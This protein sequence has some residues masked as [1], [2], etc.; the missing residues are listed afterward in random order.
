[1]GL[2]PRDVPRIRRVGLVVRETDM[3][4]SEWLAGLRDM[5]RR[6]GLGF[7]DVERRVGLGLRDIE[8]RVGL[9]FRDAERRVGLGFRAMERREGLGLREAERRTGLVLRDIDRPP[10]WRVGLVWRERG[11]AGTSCS[12]P[13]MSQVRLLVDLKADTAI[14][15]LFFLFSNPQSTT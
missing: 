12:T 9:G 1:V 8:R 2:G 11:V 3:E 13:R 5:E 14:L 7:L 6:V 15:T 4:R 10:L